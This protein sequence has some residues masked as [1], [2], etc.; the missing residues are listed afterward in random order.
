[1]TNTI[2]LSAIVT[3]GL[4]FQLVAKFRPMSV[5]VQFAK[6]NGLALKTPVYRP[7]KIFSEKTIH[8]LKLWM[9]YIQMRENLQRKSSDKV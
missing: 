1:M 2:P 6:S 4:S 9:C 3:N 8:P 7:T 5:T